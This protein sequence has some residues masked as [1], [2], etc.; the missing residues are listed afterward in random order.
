MR[1][2]FLTVCAALV[3]INAAPAYA[4]R[5]P[6]EIRVSLKNLDLAR[7]QAVTR[8]KSRIDNAVR[9]ACMIGTTMQPVLDY[10]CFHDARAEALA[11]LEEKRTT[12]VATLAALALRD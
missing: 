2:I 8:A 11:K 9:N 1:N 12:R 7:P 3:T 4:E 10:D 5:E 6:V